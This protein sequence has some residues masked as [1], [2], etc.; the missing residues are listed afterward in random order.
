MSQVDVF[1]SKDM[2]VGETRKKGID[3][4]LGDDES[5]ATATW[6]VLDANGTPITTPPANATVTAAI[7]KAT[8]FAYIPAGTTTGDRRCIFTYTIGSETLIAVLKYS[9]K[10]KHK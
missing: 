6:Q 3:V 8:V 10:E 5:I 2:Y 4:A 7:G 9:V 1:E